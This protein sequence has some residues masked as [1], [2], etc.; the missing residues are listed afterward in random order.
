MTTNPDTTAFP[1]VEIVNNGDLPVAVRVDP[2]T[3]DIIQ[4][5]H[6]RVSVIWVSEGE[7]ELRVRASDLTPNYCL[8]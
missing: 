2:E 7:V 4:R 1:F 5:L 3:C 6:L 8:F